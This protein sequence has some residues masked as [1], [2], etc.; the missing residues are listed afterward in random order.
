MA[1]RREIGMYLGTVYKNAPKLKKMRKYRREQWVSNT[2][3]EYAYGWGP[4]ISDLDDAR[5]YLDKRQSI[6]YQEIKTA[7]FVAG[8]QFLREDSPTSVTIGPATIFKSRRSVD[9][10]MI[11]F[12]GGV[13]SRA[14]GQ[15]LI[16]HSALGLSYRH[17]VPTLWELLPWSFV[18]D[19]FSNIGDVL[20]AWSSQRL[21]LAWGCQTTRR[22]RTADYIDQRG[23]NNLTKVEGSIFI[24]GDI[25]SVVSSFTRVPISTPPLPSVA[26]EIPGF[27]IQWINMA[28]LLNTRKKLG[29]YR[30]WV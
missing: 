5:K 13:A 24:P 12:R 1:L 15:D 17:F 4:L 26:F 6:L 19:Y 16:N 11:I 8:M 22:K 21:S 18:I 20:S 27:G 25:K 23:A 14:T 9:E 7:K 30:L 10:Y 28:A 29:A 3:L 2:W